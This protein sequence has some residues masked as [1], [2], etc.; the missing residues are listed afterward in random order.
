MAWATLAIT[1]GRAAAGVTPAGGELP[2]VGGSSPAYFF[3]TDK[4]LYQLGEEVHAVH[5]LTNEGDEDYRLRALNTPAFDMYVYNDNAERVWSYNMILLPNTWWL[6]VAPG[7]S[8]VRE[9]TWD[10]TDY[11]GNLVSPGRYELVGVIYGGWDVRR[12][13]TIIPEP[14]S[15]A[16]L[17]GG[18][19]LLHGLRRGRR[20]AQGA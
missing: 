10:M 12:E 1:A 16:L 5:R 2:V 6:T 11:Q 17:L 14:C 13:I 15:I 20:S 7:E 9:Y 18:C 8:I 19:W 4:T 3:E